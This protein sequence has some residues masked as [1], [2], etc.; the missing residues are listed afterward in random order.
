[1]NEQQL[2]YVLAIAKHEQI[3]CAAQ[4]LFITPAALRT[5][6][7]RIEKELGVIL[8]DREK[9][10]LLPTRQGHIVLHYG[11]QLFEIMDQLHGELEQAYLHQ[12]HKVCLALCNSAYIEGWLQTFLLMHPQ[13]LLQQKLLEKDALFAALQNET[14]DLG[15][16]QWYGDVSGLEAHILLED[17]YLVV[18]PR[19]HPF[20][21]QSSI[22]MNQ[23]IDCPILCLPPCPH[24][25]RIAEKLY[26]Q[27]DLIP[28]II[29]E[30]ERAMLD[31]LFAACKGI[32]F[33]SR[34]MNYLQHNFR[35]SNYQGTAQQ[36]ILPIKDTDCTFQIA[37][38]WKQGRTL[39]A[40][41]QQLK[42]FILT[43]YPLWN[44][45]S[46]ENSYE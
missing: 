41:A 15:I 8:F 44:S 21:G 37:L 20:A 16:D 7:S 1:M 13:I 26:Q 3:N 36:V 30:G 33:T 10:R 12:S 42:E 11:R 9:E 28:N 27:A 43:K 39:P 24:I 17:T 29:Y 35:L 38:Y 34:Q 22:T 4:E 2:K 40:M 6:L 23:L 32:L 45:E 18:L 5:A 25:T 46:K 19:Q 14:V 31:R